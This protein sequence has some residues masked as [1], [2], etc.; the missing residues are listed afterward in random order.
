MSFDISLRKSRKKATWW[1]TLSPGEKFVISGSI[2]TIAAC[3]AVFFLVG[4]V[5]TGQAQPPPPVVVTLQAGNP[6]GKTE[7]PPQPIPAASPP[8]ATPPSA[9]V[10][11]PAQGKVAS[12]AR[13]KKPCKKNGAVSTGGAEGSGCHKTYVAGMLIEGEL[14]EVVEDNERG[15][16]DPN[17]EAA[18]ISALRE[19]AEIAARQGRPPPGPAALIK[20]PAQPAE[21]V[22]AAPVQ[23]TESE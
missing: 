14:G 20:R 23:L 21:K 2:L 3:C 10:A 5:R 8:L 15:T 1:Q 4:P 6:A 16:P 13:Q 11:A 18:R 19:A 12:E 7:A 9:P 22:A 17:K